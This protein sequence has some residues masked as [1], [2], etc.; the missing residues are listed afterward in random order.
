MLPSETAD[1]TSPIKVTA[2]ELEP[3]LM[4]VTTSTTSLYV[5]LCEPAQVSALLGI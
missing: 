5:A 4:T 2:P 1:C 3:L